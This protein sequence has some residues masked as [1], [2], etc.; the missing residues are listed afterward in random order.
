MIASEMH[1][2]LQI[3]FLLNEGKNNSEISKKF[4]DIKYFYF[5]KLTNSSRKIPLNRLKIIYESLLEF[6]LKCKTKN[7]E[8]RI[9]IRTVTIINMNMKT[10]YLII[11]LVFYFLCQSS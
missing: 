6:D 8:K 10:I 7:F 4:E 11:S 9:R 3:K 5:N 1:K 2:I